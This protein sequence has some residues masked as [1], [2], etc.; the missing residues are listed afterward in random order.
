MGHPIVDQLERSL[1]AT[2]RIA[3]AFP[4]EKY[5]YT[6]SAGCMAVGEMIEHVATNFD[7][8]I[9]PIA[10]LLGINTAGNIPNTPVE[11]LGWSSRRFLDVLTQVP[12]DRWED[13]VKYPDGFEMRIA[14]AAL[15]SLEHD[16]HHRGQLITYSHMLRLH[17]PK[18][19]PKS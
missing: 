6:P 7:W 11:H 5:D 15:V 12:N 17:L 18:R 4:S 10:A 14:S 9:G 8:V 13:I 1:E 16:V 19:W 3:E 2:R